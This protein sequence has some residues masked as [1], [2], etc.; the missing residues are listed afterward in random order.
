VEG[1]GNKESKT[2]IGDLG[3][4]EPGGGGDH[5]V[6]ARGRSGESG[7]KGERKQGGTLTSTWKRNFLSPQ[8]ALQE[9]DGG[10]KR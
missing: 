7:G 4:L 3:R 6:L 10:Q 9:G 5:E 1:G 8:G 2:L